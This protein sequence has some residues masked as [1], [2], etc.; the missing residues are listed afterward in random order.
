MFEM[1]NPGESGVEDV[2]TR[3]LVRDK[4]M[5][6]TSTSSHKSM[7]TK[8]HVITEALP[9]HALTSSRYGDEVSGVHYHKEHQAGKSDRI[10]G[11]QALA[12]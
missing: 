10:I 1:G 8:S 4:M 2:V 6:R 7:R 11:P 12:T 9:S 5:S 3:G